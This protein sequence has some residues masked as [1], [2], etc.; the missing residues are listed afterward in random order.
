MPFEEGEEKVSEDLGTQSENSV[1]WW[2][3]GLVGCTFCPA[4]H[5]LAG[6][7]R[8]HVLLFP[9]AGRVMR[10]L[11]GRSVVLAFSSGKERSFLGPV[12]LSRYVGT[13]IHIDASLG[14]R[15]LFAKDTSS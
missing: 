5:S 3:P 11:G 9:T 15:K 7:P 10:P 13:S 8:T 12:L 6:F 14:S 1:E 4:P 2:G